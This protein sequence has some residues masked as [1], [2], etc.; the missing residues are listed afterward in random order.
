M[1]TLVLGGARSGKS[2][3]A[4]DL[5]RQSARPV[6]YVATLSV[7]GD[8]DLAARVR[9]HRE[10]RPNDWTTVE[11]HEDLAT[12]L[13]ATKGTVLIDSLGPWLA[14]QREMT[15]DRATLCQAVSVR[16]DD[17]VIVSDEV[18]FGVHPE[19]PMGRA[20]RD[21]LGTLNQAVAEVADEV[22]LVVAGRALLLPTRPS[23]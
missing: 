22:Y 11:G 20:F 2:K 15:V 17:T 6:T 8:A 4:E 13:S 10:R 12:L 3:F 1:I 5:A 7:E 23:T 16:P 19:T 14:G 21:A 18:G 9:V